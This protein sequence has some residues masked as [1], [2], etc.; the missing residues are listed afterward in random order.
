MMQ[1]AT[2]RHASG[3]GLIANP[4]RKDLFVSSGNV[5]YRLV[6]AMEQPAF[7]AGAEALHC[8]V[9]LGSSVSVAGRA[10]FS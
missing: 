9:S 10:R 8:E 6:A 4:C 1:R 5:L 3:S 7:A 2:H